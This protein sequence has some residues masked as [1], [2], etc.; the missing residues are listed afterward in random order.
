MVGRTWAFKEEDR[1]LRWG[2]NVRFY[3]GINY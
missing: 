2:R 1:D 3:N